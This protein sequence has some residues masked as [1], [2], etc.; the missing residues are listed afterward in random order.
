MITITVAFFSFFFSLIFTYYA[1]DDA[2]H[3][4]DLCFSHLLAELSNA[5]GLFPVL[6]H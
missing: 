3:I 2:S 4:G 5:C 6:K 1:E